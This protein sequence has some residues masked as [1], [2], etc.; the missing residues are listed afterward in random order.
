[1]IQLQ[2]SLKRHNGIL[3]LT[4]NFER[5]YEFYLQ[6]N[7]KGCIYISKYLLLGRMMK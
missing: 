6:L 5:L 2:Y 4:T 7:L 1:M 3:I